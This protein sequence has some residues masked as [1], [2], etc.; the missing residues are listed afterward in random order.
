MT[1]GRLLP[2]PTCWIRYCQK[3]I[4]WKRYIEWWHFQRGMKKKL[5]SIVER[6]KKQQISV[7]Y[8]WYQATTIP[9]G[10]RNWQESKF[11]AW[12]RQPSTTVAF[13]L[14]KNFEL[15]LFIV[16]QL[17]H[18]AG[19]QTD[20]LPV[21]CGVVLLKVVAPKDRWDVRVDKL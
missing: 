6:L 18:F 12:R 9:N 1:D 15:V 17:V 10:L 8:V 7:L 3:S 20:V 4:C 5:M 2:F 21:C 13:S 14:L 11:S 16:L 19:Q